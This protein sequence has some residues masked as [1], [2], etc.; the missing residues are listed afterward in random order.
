VVCTDDNSLC[1]LESCSNGG[2][3]IQEWNTFSCNCD[4]TSFT[5]PTC[6]DGLLNIPMIPVAMI[7]VVF[8]DDD[9][10]NNKNNNINNN[11]VFLVC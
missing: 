4:L 8:D 9:D 7:I 1:T 10:V 11:S 3:C 2:D 6:D 5:G